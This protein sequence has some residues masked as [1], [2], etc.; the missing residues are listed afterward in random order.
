L[1]LS[2]CDIH[3]LLDEVEV[4]HLTNIEYPPPLLQTS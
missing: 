2:S 1:I 3:H 4:M